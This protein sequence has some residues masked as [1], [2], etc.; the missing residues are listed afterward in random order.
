MFGADDPPQQITGSRP[1]LYA[2]VWLNA[3]DGHTTPASGRVT[4]T[5]GLFAVY[6]DKL[7]LVATFARERLISVHKK[8]K[9]QSNSFKV[10]LLKTRLYAE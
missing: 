5:T 4:R 2:T 3:V 7:F 9:Y 8:I 1:I 10:L 6:S